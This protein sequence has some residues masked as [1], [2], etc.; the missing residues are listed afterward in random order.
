MSSHQCLAGTRQWKRSEVSSGRRSRTSIT[1]RSPQSAHVVSIR[2]SRVERG[3]DP[4]RV[5]GAVRVPRA[6]GG[7]DEERCRHRRERVGHPDRV[8]V[9]D[10]GAGLVQ[11]PPP[12]DHLGGRAELVRLG[13]APELDEAGV[14]RVAELEVADVDHGRSANACTFA[15]ASSVTSSP[16]PTATMRGSNDG[17]ARQRLALLHRVEREGAPARLE[18]RPRHDRVAHDQEAVLGEV[19]GEV[20]G[21]VARRVEHLQRPDRVAV[22][23]R[24]VDGARPV[25]RPVEEE[26]DLERIGPER[27]HRLEAGGLRLALAGDHVRLPRVRQ[28]LRARLALERRDA[29]E[30]GAVRVRE[31][32]PLHVTRRVTQRAH[33]REHLAGVVREQRVDERQLAD[34]L[35]EEGADAP[36]LGAAEAVD[37]RN[38]LPHARTRRQGANALSTPSSAGA[39]SG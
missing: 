5:P 4:E 29:P 20:A 3:A 2:P 19:E 8:A 32:D 25:R 35:D 1:R 22:R 7:L 24:A 38:E 14:R 10:E 18:P 9:E 34:A 15:A 11:A 33:R 17:E 37:A 36:A 28:H 26:P 39:T 6:A 16:W 13:R 31:H 21:R 23:D 12:R 27:P 30:M